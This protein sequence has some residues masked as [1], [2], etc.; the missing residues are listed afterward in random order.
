MFE[1]WRPFLAALVLE[2][3]A[4]FVYD[5][6]RLGVLA[7]ALVAIACVAV[8]CSAA[9]FFPRAVALVLLALATVS[10]LSFAIAPLW[11]ERWWYLA[12]LPLAIGAA[13]L[14]MRAAGT[15]SHAV[16]DDTHR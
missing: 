14:S 15:A 2:L 6:V 8:V 7:G 13:V 10:A 1:Y 3:A 4:L 11:N 5:T 9:F 16:R 12:L